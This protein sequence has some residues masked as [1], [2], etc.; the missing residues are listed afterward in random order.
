MR[1]TSIAPVL[2]ATLCGA[3]VPYSAKS[4]DVP[5]PAQGAVPAGQYTLDKA[6]ASLLFRVSHLGFSH[7]TARFSRFDA[8][9]RFDPAKPAGNQLTVS[10][11]PTSINADNVPAGFLDTLQGPEWLDAGKFPQMT[12]RSNRV[13]A[14]GANGL[15]I[16]GDLT[17]HGVTRPVVLDA[18]YNGGYLGHPMDPHARV[19][20][21]AHGTLKRSEFG[22]AYGIPQPGSTMG[23]SDAVE[24]TI[25]AEFSGPAWKA[26]KG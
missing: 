20:F 5:P 4:V 17:L 9:A 11:D 6:H 25:E 24:F 7:W 10:I 22:I 23:V 12:Y 26:P 18:T 3:A 19:G 2:L 13:E 1:K 15:R 16:Y 21:S 8:T 14:A